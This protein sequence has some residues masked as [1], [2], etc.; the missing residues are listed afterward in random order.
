[1]TYV[2]SYTQGSP[3]IK[4]SMTTSTVPSPKDELTTRREKSGT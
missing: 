3:T 1:M 2:G 4:S